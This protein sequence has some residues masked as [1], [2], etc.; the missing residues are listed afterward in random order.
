VSFA[1]NIERRGAVYYWRRRLP[2][3]LASKIGKC[4]VKL[5]LQTKEPL[6]ARILSAELDALALTLFHSPE[7]VAMTKQQ[8]QT[9]FNGTGRVHFEKRCAAHNFDRHKGRAHEAL[10]LYGDRVTGHAYYVLAR[11][12]WNAQLDQKDREDLKSSG[13]KDT[14]I[15][16]VEAQL[17]ELGRSGVGPSTF[18]ILSL[19]KAVGAEESSQNGIVTPGFGLAISTAA[20]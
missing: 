18:K 9:I 14:E 13:L 11:K 8:L 4:Y 20:R 15:R 5:S 12:G 19:L 6:M 16:D 7:V 2:V 1:A 3:D 10:K 17:F